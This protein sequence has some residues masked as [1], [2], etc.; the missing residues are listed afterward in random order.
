MAGLYEAAGVNIDAGN[1]AV[2]RIKTLVRKTYNS[3]VLGDL[4]NFGGL[5]AFPVRDFAD[6]IL[7]SSTDGVG[8]KLKVAFALQRYDTVGCD[9]VNHCV[10]DILVQGARPLFFLD[11]IGT[12]VVRPEMIEDIVKGLAKGCSENGCVLIGGETAEMPGIYSAGEFDLVGTIIG[13]VERDLLITGATIG[14]GDLVLGLPSL[15]L[16]TNG[17]SLARHICFEQLGLSPQDGV[18]GIEDTIGE[19][20]LAPHR[21]YFQAV[22]PLVAQKVIKG[23]AHIT[24]GGFYDNIPRILPAGCGVDINKG[25]WPT[26]PIF[27]FLQ[28]SANIPDEEAYRVFNMGIGMVVICD[29]KDLPAIKAVIP[30]SY[31]IGSV[32]KGDKK[33]TVL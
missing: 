6:P 32:V 8:T 17:Y 2:K 29:S 33:V 15:G 5:F 21:S 13:V 16:H 26:L 4:G 28:K 18:P 27:E 14:P 9:L 1:E 19:A 7:V 31:L 30:E 12:G 3:Q 20:L 24:G 25:T 10:N 22:Y 11:Y 23:L